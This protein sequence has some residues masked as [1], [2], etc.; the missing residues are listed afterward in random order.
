MIHLRVKLFSLAFIASILF[1]GNP[2]LVVSAEKSENLTLADMVYADLAVRNY[3]NKVSL[4]YFDG[5]TDNNITINSD[6]Q[7]IPASTI[8]LYVA[9]YAYDQAGNGKLSLDQQI[10]IDAKNVAPSEQAPGAL[11][12][13]QTGDTVSL[14]RVIQQMIVQS[15]NTA[16]NTLL[17]VLDRREVT[18]YVHDLGLINTNIGSKLN[19]DDNQQ[20]LEYSVPGY[21][22]NTTTSDDYQTAFILINGNRI[23]GSN[24]LFDIL[25]QQKLNNM[26]PLLLPTDTVVA[27]KTGDLDPLYHDGGIVVTPNKRY[28][29]SIFSNIGDPNVIA[30]LSQLIYLKDLSLVGSV[31]KTNP[32][33]S[34]NWPNEQPVDPM[35]ANFEENSL[36]LAEQSSSNIVAPP[37][38]A[39]DLGIK[40]SD[41]SLSLGSS[42]LP[43]VVITSDSKLHFFVDI[44]QK[45]TEPLIIGSKFKVNYKVEELKLKLAEVEDLS[46]RGKKIEAQMLLEDID[47]DLAKVAKDPVV[48]KSQDL[49]TDIQQVSETRFSLLSSELKSTDNE[50]KAVVIKKIADQARNTLKNV[51]P[52]VTQAVTVTNIN[53]KPVV[54]QI[55]S[56]SNNNLVVKTATG[57]QLTVPNVEVKMREEGQTQVS[58]SNTSSIPVGTTIALVGNENRG[59]VVPTFV[60]TK[61]PKRF[62]APIPATVIKVNQRD[63]TIVVSTN[64]VPAQVDISPDTKIRG[65]DTTVGLSNIKPGDNIVL[66]GEEASTPKSTITP[67]ST[68]APATSNPSATTNKAPS[69]G[70]NNK[71][72]PSGSTKKTPEVIRPTVIQVV[73]KS[74]SG[75]VKKEEPKKEE[76]KKE[77]P[78]KEEPKKEENTPK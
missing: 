29:L 52:N 43:K 10:T 38:T 22:S 76:P 7:W 32:I 40:A 13:L 78:K 23:P 51:E 42:E 4:N 33:S 14:Y 49:Q 47:N 1:L 37:I 69:G 24:G 27:H 19:L 71:M 57:D 64:G 60:L 8:K 31:I 48:S 73:G 25:S 58:V 53:Q 72:L 54:G 67:T 9:M 61:L 50:Q 36:V 77:E 20:Q 15:D 46:I 6:K 16:F 45:I 55:V 12:S 65:Q 3:L 74:S 18:K 30:H 66:H 75:P 68:T 26:I 5:N 62:A 28:V 35:L 56:S 41:L 11:P 63:K 17:D 2:G 21:G 39:S 59:E 34:A 70:S 44:W